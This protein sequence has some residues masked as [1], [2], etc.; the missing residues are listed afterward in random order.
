MAMFRNKNFTK[1]DYDCTNV[2][3]CESEFAPNENYVLTSHE[4][5]NSM[6]K[7]SIQPL[8]IENGV[9]FYGYM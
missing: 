4:E 6:L 5:L 2:V 9:Q 8:F 3:A 1:R 7:S